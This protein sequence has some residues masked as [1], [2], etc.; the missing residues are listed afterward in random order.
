[1]ESHEEDKNKAK[2]KNKKEKTRVH[3]LKSPGRHVL[4][5]LKFTYYPE[6]NILS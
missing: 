2:N 1:M 5:M 6:K 4:V 3:D